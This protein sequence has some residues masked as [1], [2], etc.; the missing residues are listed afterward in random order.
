MNKAANTMINH[1]VYRILLNKNGTAVQ[2]AV[3]EDRDGKC[4]I[5]FY[6]EWV[7]VERGAWN[8]HTV[9]EY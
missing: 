4:Y 1:G 5:K 7:E 8:Y 3:Y 2:R 9:E 6:G